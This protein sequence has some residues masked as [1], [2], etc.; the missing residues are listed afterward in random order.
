VG[1]PRGGRADGER[2]REV[3]QG[4]VFVDAGRLDVPRRPQTDAL[5]FRGGLRQPG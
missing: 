3:G 4:P 2:R 1:A 5:E